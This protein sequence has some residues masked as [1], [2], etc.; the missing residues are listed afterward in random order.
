MTKKGKCT[1]FFRQMPHAPVEG[2]QL[3]DQP[4]IELLMQ[5]KIS[6]EEACLKANGKKIFERFLK[7]PADTK[8]PP[9]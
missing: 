1:S 3:M 9:K 4:I 7:K 6:P 2:M 5:K 8:V